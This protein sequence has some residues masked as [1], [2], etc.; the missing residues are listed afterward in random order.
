MLRIKNFLGR[1]YQPLNLVEISRENI[2]SNYR[3]LS[4]INRNIKIAPVLKSNAYGHGISIVG[5]DFDNLNAPFICVDSLYEAYELLKIKVK[6]QIL[7]MGFVSPKSLNT[8]KLPFSFAVYNKELVDAIEKFQPHAK[9]HIFV[10]TGMHREGV[11][12]EEL[13]AFVK[14]IQS[15]THLEIEGL[16]SHFAMGDD[17]KN[18]DTRKQVEAFGTAKQILSDHGIKPKWIHIANSAGLLNSR[19]YKN[20]LGNMARVGKSSYGI[21]PR[22]VN[23]DLKPAL[24]LKT[25]IAQV[26]NLKK[27]EKVGYDFSYTAEKDMKMAIIPIGYFE[28]VDRR[29]SNKGYVLVKNKYCKIIGRVSMNISI[30]DVSHVLNAK[31][32]QEVI[33]YS[34]NSS[35][36][37]SIQNSAKICNTIPYEILSHLA[38]STKRSLV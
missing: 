23:K 4:L 8:K 5:K 24:T 16:M 26:K 22:K 27:G 20:K 37:N 3:Y 31:V 13:P 2:K 15:N 36:K 14:Y 17:I 38:S 11:R 19:E 21:D 28:G 30:I 7:I 1:N 10:D 35:A 32:G 25:Q 29:L 34:N 18:E 9:V 33:V 12:L 6:T